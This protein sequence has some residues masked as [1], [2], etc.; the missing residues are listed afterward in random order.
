VRPAEGYLETLSQ[1]I[2]ENSWLDAV[3]PGLDQWDAWNEYQSEPNRWL[4]NRWEKPRIRKDY[5][6]GWNSLLFFT[7]SPWAR[8]ETLTIGVASGNLAISRQSFMGVGGFDEQIDGLGDDREFGLR[9]WWYGYRVCMFPGAVAFHLREAQGGLR[10]TKSRWARLFNP[11]PA[12]GWVYFHLKWFPGDP[13]QQM[14]RQLIVKWSKRPWTL[15][16]KLVRLR[17][18]ISLAKV[19]LKSGPRYISLPVPRSQLVNAGKHTT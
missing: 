3:Q 9:L 11:D 2:A 16:I 7:S 17:R 4:T 13:Y 8:Y 18:S 19:R 6:V 10:Q 14:I 12:I 5:P 1:F 15:P